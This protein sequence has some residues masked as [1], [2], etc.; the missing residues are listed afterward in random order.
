M[1]FETENV[2][3]AAGLG[4]NYFHEIVHVYLAALKNKGLQEGIA[5]YYGGSLGKPLQWHVDQLRLFIQENPSF[6]F[7]I[8]TF[9]N[10]TIY[11]KS[12]AGA[13]VE[14]IICNAIARKDGI[15]GLKRIMNYRNVEEVVNTEFK[16]NRSFDK[17]I[18]HL[19]LTYK[20]NHIP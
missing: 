18:K 2:V 3:Y 5:V 12:N 1:A 19:L 6:T 15:N 10:L 13:T 17:L 20:S 11:G 16:D 7:D 4:K 8:K 9:K 14:A